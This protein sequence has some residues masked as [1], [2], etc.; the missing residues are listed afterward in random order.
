MKEFIRE[1]VTIM[2]I[3]L[4]FLQM[5]HRGKLFIDSLNI[6]LYNFECQWW[7]NLGTR[8]KNILVH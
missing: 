5:L 1:K 8:K 2:K 3:N 4:K 6:N 7:K